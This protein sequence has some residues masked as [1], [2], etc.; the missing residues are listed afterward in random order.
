MILRIAL[1]DTRALVASGGARS[2]TRRR[3]SASSFLSVTSPACR[4]AVTR[5][6]LAENEDGV[7]A[8]MPPS[9]TATDWVR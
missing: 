2:P 6:G 3:A 4:P 9:R 5:L 7:T 1:S 8:T